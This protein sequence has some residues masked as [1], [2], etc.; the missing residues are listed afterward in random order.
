MLFFV[1]VFWFFVVVVVVVVPHGTTGLLAHTYTHLIL[2]AGWVCPSVRP[3]PLPRYLRVLESSMTI[4]EHHS[5]LQ[6][7]SLGLV[8]GDLIA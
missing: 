7:A 4:T 1:F 2:Y 3:T 6:S 5:Y 8:F